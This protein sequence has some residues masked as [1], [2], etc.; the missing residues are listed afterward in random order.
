[1]KVLSTKI[2]DLKVI[3]GERFLDSRGYFRELYK[4]KIIKK[5]KFIFW[6]ASKSKKNVLRGIHLQVKSPQAKYISV[7]KGEII[8]VVVD[9]RKKSKTFGK[10]FKIRLSEKNCKSLLIPE[11]FGHAFYGTKSENIVIYSNSNYRSKKNEVGILWNDKDLK[12]KWPN[13]N[14]IISKKD[15]LNLSFKEFRKKFR[16]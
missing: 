12:I 1:M 2:K 8:D 10:H 16:K 6:C 4:K 5:K 15:K 7:L 11:G 9:L 3:E 13:K 14:L